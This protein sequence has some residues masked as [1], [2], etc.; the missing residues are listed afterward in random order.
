MEAANPA[1]H[2]L[3]QV[4]DTRDIIDLET[5]SAHLIGADVHIWGPS[6]KLTGAKASNVPLSWEEIVTAV[7]NGEFIRCGISGSD[8]CLAPIV[9]DGELP[10]AI[11]AGPFSGVEDGYRAVCSFLA[12]LGRII[13]SMIAASWHNLDLYRQA[14]SD[15]RFKVNELSYLFEISKS[16]HGQLDFEENSNCFLRKVMEFSGAST[17]VIMLLDEEKQ[18]IRHLASAGCSPMVRSIELSPG[19]DLSGHVIETGEYGVIA[20]MNESEFPLRDDFRFSLGKTVSIISVP[21]KIE[22]RSLGVLHLGYREMHYPVAE[23]INLLTV[24]AHEAAVVIEHGRLFKEVSRLAVTDGLTRLNNHRYLQQRLDEEL[25][26]AKRFQRPL[27]VLMLDID[28]FKRYNDRFGHLAGDILL[29]RLSGLLESSTRSMDILARY[30]G[31]EFCIVLPETGV[32][33]AEL[34]AERIR[35]EVRETLHYHNQEDGSEGKVTVSIGISTFPS[36]GQS[37]TML[38]SN[39]D[40]ALYRAKQNGRNRVVVASRLSKDLIEGVADAFRGASE[41]EQGDGR[42]VSF[43]GRYKV[44][45]IVLVALVNLFAQFVFRYSYNDL[46]AMPYIYLHAVMEL[47]SVA[48]GVIIF[49]IAFS[50]AKRT[51][52][53][54]LSMLGKAFLMMSVLDLLH[55][56]T[57]PGGIGIMSEGSNGMTIALWICSRLAGVVM[58]TAAVFMPRRRNHH[59]LIESSVQESLWPILIALLIYLTM[60]RFAL[61]RPFAYTLGKSVGEAA[62]YMEVII[63][64]FYTIAALGFIRL[65]RQG[66]GTLMLMF[67]IGMLSMVFSAASVIIMLGTHNLLAHVYKS[68]AYL[69]ILAGFWLLERAGVMEPDTVAHDA[70]S[71]RLKIENREL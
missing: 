32:A 43:L 64:F 48:V 56:M 16:L 17:G 1:R 7:G 9:L 30:G 71:G 27:S 53:N 5:A 45:L 35:R 24:V 12:A 28:H 33:E 8:Y 68:L 2:D 52:D 15:L 10:A 18:I 31:E 41:S 25:E 58:I 54:R 65:Y 19:E 50:A 37:K 40:K 70:V 42:K 22:G 26:R 61:L 67:I 14:E 6:G 20:D 62:I 29:K 11:V 66:G 57:F 4:L 69:V 23:E 38:L 51:G 44:H 3:L 36:D 55:L 34:V 63:A 59:L 49:Y 39:S 46:E 60:E 21:L 47:Y 13:S